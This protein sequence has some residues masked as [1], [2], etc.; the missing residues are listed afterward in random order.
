MSAADVRS[1]AHAAVGAAR[2]EAAG[3]ELGD[4]S[5]AIV[6]VVQQLGLQGNPA[7]VASNIVG[8]A[9]DVERVLQTGLKAVRERLG[10][11]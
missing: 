6:V 10:L 1:I 9:S 4:E 2:L 5:V 7:Y 3:T 11:S 8:R